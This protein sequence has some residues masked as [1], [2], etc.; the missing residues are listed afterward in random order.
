MNTIGQRPIAVELN[1]NQIQR[2]DFDSAS[3]LIYLGLATPGSAVSE[4][5][6]QIKKY[7][8]SSGNL[9]SVTLA[10][11]VDAYNQVWDD[12]AVLSYS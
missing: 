9:V 11:G 4:S 8:W 1:L 2:L 7:T 12:R 3:N 6:W 10:N 5:K